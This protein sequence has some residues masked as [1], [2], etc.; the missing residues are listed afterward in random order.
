[1]A[2]SSVTGSRNLVNIQMLGGISTLT[3]VLPPNATTEDGK[4]TGP[5][6]PGAFAFIDTAQRNASPSNT[7]LQLSGA[8]QNQSSSVVQAL[9]F[10]YNQQAQGVL[11]SGSVG[12]DELAAASGYYR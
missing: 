5:M 12:S 1:M 6:A 11:G 4:L 3:G 10:L 2:Y 9:N 7:A 8:F